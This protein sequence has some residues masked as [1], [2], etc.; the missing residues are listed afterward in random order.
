M[1]AFPSR[2]RNV[3]AAIGIVLLASARFSL[4][5]Q[6]SD[7][8]LFSDDSLFGDDAIVE[9]EE[10]QTGTFSDD[11]NR[12]VLFEAGSVKVGGA[13]TTS[14]G[15]N[16]PLYADDGKSFGERLGETT[17]A[18]RAEATLFVDAR[19]TNV[20]R[21]YTKFGLAYPFKSLASSSANTIRI[22]APPM[23]QFFTSVSTNITDYFALK[24]LFTDFSAA[25]R[26]FF[27]FGKH[28]V[29][30]G[31]GY[32]FSPVSDMINTSMIDP[33][34]TENQ[35]DGS[36]NLRTQIT[37]P[38]TQ[39]CLWLYLIPSTDFL[40]AGSA[41]TYLKKTALAAKVDLVFGGWE[42]GAGGYFRYEDSP[43]AM[44]TASGS[45]FGKVGVFAEAVY[46]YGTQSEWAK[47][48]SYGG[49]TSVFFAT[50]GAS[51]A[52]QTPQIT[53]AAQY[54]YDG[55][56]SDGFDFAVAAQA[57]SDLTHNFLTK[58]HNVA[59]VINFARVFGTT[60][61]SAS[62]FAMANFG[63]EALPDLMKSAVSSS[64]ATFFNAGTFSATLSWTPFRNFALGFGP[65]ITFENWEKAPAVSAQLSATLGGGRF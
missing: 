49:K 59:A 58:G 14:I 27:R 31:T 19:P 65:Y 28:T 5:A 41:E 38:N 53:I 52:W 63:K 21:M 13:F 9:I 54:Y 25:D 16:A 20:L 51:Y 15:I 62:I 64:A 24:E 23:E 17:L 3:A 34:N 61:V 7:D 47:D 6:S 1:F 43:K 50:L 33:E 22:G 45:L 18:P 39:N 48:K 55:F 2:S 4:F 46:Q 35:V 30:W 37:F 40:N 12:G 29:S 60:D 26:V 32:F 10:T 57:R 8:D 42:I 56:N 11:L 44:L 36:L